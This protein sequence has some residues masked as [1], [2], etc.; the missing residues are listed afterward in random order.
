MPDEQTFLD[1]IFPEKVDFRSLFD[2]YFDM[3]K[4]D[5]GGDFHHIII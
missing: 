4:M 5:L 2:T 3:F 1:T